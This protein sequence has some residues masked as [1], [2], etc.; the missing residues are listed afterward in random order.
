MSSPRITLRVCALFMTFVA[1][2]IFAA[3]R[4]DDGVTLIDRVTRT[5]GGLLAAQAIA[6]LAYHIHVREATY[7][8]DGI[9]VVDRQGRMRIDLYA[10]GKR[11]Y[12]ECYDG[13]R[14][15]QMDRDGKVADSSATGTLT[16]WH[17]TQYPGQILALA[18]L[19]AHGHRIESIGRERIDG[20]AYDV[21]K[22]TMSDGF[23]TY[24]YVNVRTGRIERSRDVRA[25]HPDMDPKRAPLDTAYAD[26]R[27]VDGVL[28]PFAETQ[29]DLKTGKW[30]QTATVQSIRRLPSL[31]DA[32]FLRGS[33]P[34]SA[35]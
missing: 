9:Y 33:A 10:D 2:P 4:H 3:P 1:Q 20:V 18:E 24:R 26:F 16:L 30:N 23:E 14:G 28:R 6:A 8:V 32:L 15:W 35:L 7:E 34:D 22:L 13:K 11:V 31:P 19:P 29:T 12:T 5:S 17:G 25:P 27:K 21:L